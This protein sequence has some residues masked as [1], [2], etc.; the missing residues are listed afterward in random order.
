MF[1]AKAVASLA[2]PIPQP[3]DG[4]QQKLLTAKENI[5]DQGQHH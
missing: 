4:G 2:S 1:Y 5:Q 3:L